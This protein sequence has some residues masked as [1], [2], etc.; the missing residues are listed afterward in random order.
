MSTDVLPA[1]QRAAL[2]FLCERQSDILDRVGEVAGTQRDLEAFARAGV[3]RIDRTCGSIKDE[4]RGHGVELGKVKSCLTASLLSGKAVRNGLN[5]RIVLVLDD[6]LIFR[7]AC[8]RVLA[9]AGASVVQAGNL[10]EIGTLLTTPVDA[11]LL[12]VH[13]PDGCG[14]QVARAVRGIR[15]DALI[16]MTSGAPDADGETAE[17]GIGASFL[18]KPFDLDLLFNALDP[19]RR[20]HDEDHG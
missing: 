19:I 9:D 6:E 1:D 13:L 10:A 11:A 2:Q 15:P 7:R 8:V 20:H 16:V 17:L 4:L 5:G 3:T 14:Y 18:P 12:D